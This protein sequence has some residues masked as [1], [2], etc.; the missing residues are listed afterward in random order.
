MDGAFAGELTRSER[1]AGERKRV[2]TSQAIAA[3]AGIG[4]NVGIVYDAA[5]F[6]QVKEEWASGPGYANRPGRTAHPDYRRR[7]W[8]DEL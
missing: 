3:H 7:K 1:L 5:G 6:E 8:V 2:Y 4:G